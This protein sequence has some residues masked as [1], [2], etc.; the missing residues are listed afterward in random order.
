MKRFVLLFTLVL[1]LVGAASA[2][3]SE[4]G[5]AK[6]NAVLASAKTLCFSSDS[7]VLYR[8]DKPPAYADRYMTSIAAI[9]VAAIA[10]APAV[11]Y[12]RDCKTA[13]LV[14]R[15]V[16]DTD[17]PAT[18]DFKVISADSDAVVWEEKRE[19]FDLDSDL[20]HMALKFNRAVREIKPPV[21][22]TVSWA[23]SHGLENEVETKEEFCEAP[24]SERTDGG[25]A[26]ENNAY[27]SS[28]YL[29]WED[30][31]KSHDPWVDAAK[32]YHA[33]SFGIG[34]ATGKASH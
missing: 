22:M 33:G 6:G 13:D 34:A 5:T 11:A 3:L 15:V 26:K 7:G 12:A 14:L 27:C 29:Y 28:P 9:P 20:F 23:A 19:I 18:V 30:A 31:V 17:Q 32:T 1:V 2:Q 25:T 10:G 16:V 4:E 8:G 21:P 24:N